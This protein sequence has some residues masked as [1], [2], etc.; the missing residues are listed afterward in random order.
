MLHDISKLPLINDPDIFNPQKCEMSQY[1]I[2]LWGWWERD[3]EI[4]RKVDFL[5]Y[6]ISKGMTLSFSW[7]KGKN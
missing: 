5:L 1:F 3:Y 2:S 4:G 7:I 6:G